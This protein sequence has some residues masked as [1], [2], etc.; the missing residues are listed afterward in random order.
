MVVGLLPLIFLLFLAVTVYHQQNE[1]IALLESTMSRVQRSAALANV[2]DQLQSERRASYNKSITKTGQERVITSRSKTDEALEQF[3]PFEQESFE[4]FRSYTFLD[5]LSA[6]RDSLDR[7]AMTPAQITSYY[8]NIV[9]RL[10][11][12]ANLTISN[13]S[14][15]QAANDN[16]IAQRLL[17]DI[18][19]Y[20][21]IMRANIYLMLH[22]GATG[23]AEAEQVKGIYD[24]YQSYIKEYRF[25][26]S[27]DG[28]DKLTVVLNS[29]ENKWFESMLQQSFNNQ[30]LTV[31]KP[32]EEYWTMSGKAVDQIR[33]LQRGQ[34][35]I[36]VDIIDNVYKT[37]INARDKNVILLILVIALVIFTILIT[38]RSI[39]KSLNKIRL[40][41]DKIAIGATGIDLDTDQKDVIGSLARSIQELD[42]NNKV[43]SRAAD[44]IGSGNF[45]VDVT[46]RSSEDILGNAIARMKADLYEY[47][48]ENQKKL[49]L[50]AGVA[51]LNTAISGDRTVGEISEAVLNTLCAY[52]QAQVGLAYASFADNRLAF[53]SAYAV[54]DIHNIP[55]Q[56]S[57]GE[58]QLGLAATQKQTIIL[59]DVPN[60]YLK[61]K[62]GM[63]DAAPKQIIIVPLI[64]NEV[65]EGVMELASL[66]AFS[67][68]SVELLKQVSNAI[69]I[70]LGAAKSK[71]K[72]QEL[73]EETQAQAE[74]LQTQHS[75]LENL[76]TELE[77]QAQKLQASEEEL[78]VQQEELLQ[79]N[80]ELEERSKLLEERNQLI[81]EKNLDIQKKA[82][83]LETS[84][85]YKSEFLANM[86]H[87]LRTPLNSILLLSRLLAEN[88]G[89]NLTTEQVEYA[90][91]IQSSGHGLLSL[92]DEILDLSKIESGKM[93]LEYLV[94]PVA[95][96]VNDMR[97]LFGPIAKDK[98]L[99]LIMQVAENTPTIMETDK[100]RLEQIL[101]NLLSNA[102][103]FTSKGSVTLEVKPDEHRDEIL[104][105]TV[106]DTGIG[107]PKEKHYHIFEAFQ[108]AD[109]S[110]RRKFG[111]TGLGLSISR[112]LAKLLGGK[113]TLNS[114]TGKGSE[115]TVY[116]PLRK[117]TETEKAAEAQQE[118]QAEAPVP[119]PPPP[120]AKKRVYSEYIAENIP[121]A[122]PDD[123]NNVDEEDKKVLIVEDDTS[124]AKALLDF[125]RSKGYKGIVTVRGDEAL[126]LAR[127]HLPTGILLDVQ[128]PVKSGW[129]VME[130][131]KNDPL[132]RH[133]PVHMMSSHH[134]KKESLM[135]GAVD[136]INK[137]IAFEQ[138]QEVFRKIENV[139]NKENKK[140]LIV[141]ENP[142]HASALSY[143]LEQFKINAE[144]SNNVE[145]GI[146]ALNKEDID[147]VILDMGIPNANAYETLEKIKGN[148]GLENLPIIIFTGK[149]LSKAEETKIRGFADS[150]V[151]KTAH[152]YKRILDEVTLFLHLVEENNKPAPNTSSRKTL[153]A[154]QDV[155]KDK[156]VLIADD[157][158]RNIFSLTK[159][160]EGEG[161]TVISATDGKEALRG[162]DANPDID[163]ILMDIMMPEMDGYEAIRAIRGKYE[164]RD[165]PI[166]A[167][168]AK[169][170]IGDR[171]KCI[172]A[173]ASDYITKPVDIDQL[174]SLLRVWIYDRSF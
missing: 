10:N 158:V 160:L 54:D 31:D 1:K 167:V 91:V 71:A 153:G 164:Y 42:T 92:I 89:S 61:I 152:S 113:I 123:R 64:H 72:L 172:E 161:M 2:I 136:F 17:G 73:F 70:A 56:V 79:A 122:V 60:D 93:D 163:I 166:I 174:L 155:L 49:W 95:D 107:I 14:F 137:P 127:K 24:I 12:L 29:P 117:P 101:K 129:E 62:T 8:T 45:D 145:D 171:E 21:G 149:S 131:L 47:N 144:I 57:F 52:I 20:M 112:E 39:T 135:K 118:Q 98:N 97:T 141:E 43:L 33:E 32:V 30:I 9:F 51:Q 88:T 104:C 77:A 87:E 134:V 58:G 86:S 82:E 67:E 38:I 96:I 3:R 120:P 147:C 25:R 110:T 50:Q 106:R 170:M 148:P 26:V 115:F 46:P 150:I 103:K 19:T 13:I 140:V 94:T 138:I 78:R 105:F 34:L 69:A 75:E 126:D 18:V 5:Q 119:A 76:N 173:G 128:L 15:L 109:G 169:A 130:D 65:V 35:K 81:L 40:A 139:V 146:S 16:I 23:A 151:V 162:L 28:N 59:N 168:T 125:S 55:K 133:I 156:T 108:Q 36:G 4:G 7:G 68:N 159:I 142:K 11:G 37:E 6:I 66:K 154:I 143:F 116:V 165:L 132:T 48:T 99:E 124:F 63:G 121:Q 53:F 85:K 44:A 27:K 111:G 22:T 102:L 90:Q 83:D 157:D 84:T 100:M 114:D 80:Q 74:E 41:A